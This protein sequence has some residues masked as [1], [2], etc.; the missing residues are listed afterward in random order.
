M[1]PSVDG[2]LAR[3]V[4]APEKRF[5]LRRPLDAGA[6]AFARAV[7]SRQIRHG[8]HRY[9]SGQNQAQHVTVPIE[10]GTRDGMVVTLCPAAVTRQVLH[11]I[12]GPISTAAG[13]SKVSTLLLE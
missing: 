5:P 4:R 9:R 11:P 6:A 2:F 8:Q 3:H 13:I 1:Q 7:P 10:S 12:R